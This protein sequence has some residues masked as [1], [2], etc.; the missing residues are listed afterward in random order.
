MASAS[1]SSLLHPDKVDFYFWASL[2]AVLWAAYLVARSV[3]CKYGPIPRGLPYPPGPPSLP[4]VGNFFDIARGSECA[5]AYQKLA[6]KYGEPL[7][8]HRAR[9]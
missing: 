2:S 7:G 1:P 3:Q 6:Q 9:T 5:A 8:L 4:L